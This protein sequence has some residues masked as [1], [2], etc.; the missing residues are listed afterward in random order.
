ML[1]G[2]GGTTV[3][4]AKANVSVPEFTAWL[5]Y[6]RR[7]GP[8]CPNRRAD[9]LNAHLMHLMAALMGNKS[10]VSKF[11]VLQNDSERVVSMSE[12]MSTWS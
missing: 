12:A 4:Q 11:L 3:A 6:R 10:E 7:Y 5:T 1:A 2:V 8:I 9:T